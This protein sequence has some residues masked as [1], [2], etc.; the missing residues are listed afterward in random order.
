VAGVESQ[1]ADPMRLVQVL[2]DE[3]HLFLRYST[4]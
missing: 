4:A 1:L 2:E 3:G